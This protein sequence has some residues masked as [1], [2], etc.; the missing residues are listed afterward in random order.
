MQGL[1]WH[2]VRGRR[3]GVL[4]GGAPSGEPVVLVPGL[5]DGLAPVWTPLAQA[6][7]AEAPLPMRRFRCLVV[8][9]ARPLPARA[10]TREL[11]ADLADLLAVLVERPAVLLGHSMGAMVAQHLAADH[12][13]RVEAMVLSATLGRADDAFRRVVARWAGLVR[14]QRWGAF[15]RAALENSYTGAELARQRLVSDAGAVR[16][17][18]PE[19]RDR[20]L[21]LSAAC[22]T[23]DA[24]DRLPAIAAPTLVL[25][26]ER[27]RL[28][29]PHHAH[30]LA[31]GL[32]V[33][34]LRVMT[35][36]GHGF[37]EQAPERFAGAVTSFLEEL[38]RR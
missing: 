35:G 17:P 8:S 16:V 9:H 15:Q 31:T 6:M 37:P 4:E 33:G 23:H 14:E 26:G 36:L 19:L 20:H 7:L 24:L 11:A 27:D 3:F 21:A 34:R 28:C 1:R 2:R 10:D 5:T 32:P 25:A 12:P 13:D 30:R 29:R 38:A 18:P 22:V